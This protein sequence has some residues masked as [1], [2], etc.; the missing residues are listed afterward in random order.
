MS[1]LRANAS[2]EL[3]N[4]RLESS[5]VPVRTHLPAGTRVAAVGGGCQH[6]V[7]VTSRGQ[8]LAWGQGGLLGNGSTA[9]S[10]V[11]VPVLLDPGQ[12]AVGTGGSAEGNHSLALV[13]RLTGR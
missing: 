3:G 8:L 1:Q 13:L 9:L 5:S 10:T 6:S 12:I 4:G 2:G 7:A 11:P